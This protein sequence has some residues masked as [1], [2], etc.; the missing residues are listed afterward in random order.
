MNLQDRLLREF[1]EYNPEEQVE[2][3]IKY[4]GSLDEIAR[5]LDAFA[6]ELNENFRYTNW[7]LTAALFMRVGSL[8]SWNEERK[9]LATQ[10]KFFFRKGPE[11]VLD[12]DGIPA[13]LFLDRHPKLF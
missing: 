3:I 6:E 13:R 4:H 5:Q 2:I 11:P 12:L 1:P 8:R 7:I 10:Q 9:D